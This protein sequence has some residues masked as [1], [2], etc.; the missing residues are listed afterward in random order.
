MV[1]V[2]R[3]RSWGD[4]SST[5]S[6]LKGHL[7]QR[8]K[9]RGRPHV[10]RA[11]GRF[12]GIAVALFTLVPHARFASA[13]GARSDRSRSDSFAGPAEIAYREEG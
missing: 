7:H 8:G 9:T 4:D 13:V 6:K 2:G 12:V 3:W 11:M 1:A 5:R 10:S